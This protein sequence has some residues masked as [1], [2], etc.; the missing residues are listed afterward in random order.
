MPWSLIQPNQLAFVWIIDFPLFEID[1]GIRGLHVQPQPVLL[2]G[3]RLVRIFSTRDPG[4]ALSKQYDLIGN[5]HEIGG[6]SIRA[7][8]AKDLRR[9]YQVMG[10]SDAGDR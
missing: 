3:R 6:G 7:H 9:I 5:G 10:Y 1:D 8:R 2:S 4:R